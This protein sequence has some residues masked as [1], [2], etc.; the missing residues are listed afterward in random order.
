MNLETMVDARLCSQVCYARLEELETTVKALL[1]EAKADPDTPEVL[2][3]TLL[4]AED[5]VGRASTRAW[6]LYRA[7][8]NAVEQHKARWKAAR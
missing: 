1:D 5:S 8:H 7:L 2:A 6:S 4:L 3:H